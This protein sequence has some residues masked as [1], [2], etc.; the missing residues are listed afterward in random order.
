MTRIF[1]PTIY[2]RFQL[3]VIEELQHQHGVKVVG[4]TIFPLKDFKTKTPL[5]R[6]DIDT[7]FKEAF[8]LPIE[9]VYYPSQIEKLETSFIPSQKHL[10]DLKH[11]ESL[12]Y[13]IT[14][15]ANIFPIPIA[16]RRRIFLKLVSFWMDKLQEIKPDYMLY[17]DSP[18]SFNN[19]ILGEIANYLG[20]PAVRLEHTSMQDYS[21]VLKNWDFPKIPNDYLENSSAQDIFEKLPEDLQ[22]LTDKESGK[23]SLVLK[24]VKERDA[25]LN[26]S[27]SKG[28]NL[29]L[30]Q[31]FLIK[32]SANWAK[33]L[34]A[35]IGLYKQRVIL[36]DFIL[37]DSQSEALYRRK[38]NIPLF[39]QIKLNQY[40]NKISE[41]EADLNVPYVFFGMHMQPEKTT[42]PLGEEY[43]NQLLAIE[44]IATALPEGWQ[45]YVKEHPGQFNN[46][47]PINSHFRSKY[48]YDRLVKNNRVRLLSLDLDADLL[49][50][51]AKFTATIT[52]TIGWESLLFGIPCL[53]FGKAFYRGCSAAYKISS[54]ESCKAA[55]ESG[56]KMN[57]E[58]IKKECFRFIH[59]YLANNH[60]IKAVN[61]EY[62]FDYTSTPR[63]EQ[64][65]LL[66]KSLANKMQMNNTH[67]NSCLY[68]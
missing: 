17:F 47:R 39:R 3:D 14:D 9:S 51:N 67:E 25:T 61:W 32:A 65:S 48:F 4:S 50:K 21:L 26:V 19:I 40:Y 24:M 52:G 43:D 42:L 28:A 53:F 44:T 38:V 18:H 63:A 2:Q 62:K 30:F 45:L 8:V 20:V 23:D 27:K 59:Y 60:L 7:I 64:I 16:Q 57:K 12:F 22:I 6:Q 41:S 5:S 13:R 31:R 29:K 56:M 36:E 10:I 58:D 46:H 11:L 68:H 54:V 1:C 37:N 33:S 34:L 15:R 49:M 55:I 66:A 35:S